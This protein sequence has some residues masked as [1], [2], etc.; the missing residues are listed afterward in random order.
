MQ[1]VSIAGFY[2]LIFA[3][4]IYASR[5]SRGASSTDA[6]LLA[7]RG[8]PLWV[9]VMTMTAT[10]VGGGYIN[11]AA[12]AI[13]DPTLGIVWAQAPW[14]YALSMVLGGLFF[15]RRMRQQKYKTLLDP[16]ERRYGATTASWLFLPA[17]IG[18]VF[19]SAAILVALGTTF[20][21]VLDLDVRT[22]ILISAAVAVGYTLVGGLWSVAYTDVVQLVCMLGGL[23]VAIPFAVNRVG[24]IE[25]VWENAA[26]KMPPFPT[27]AGIWTWIDMALLLCLGGIP[28]QVY[29]QRVLAARD[30]R[31]AVRLSLFASLG[32]LLMAVP[33]LVIGAVGL[34]ADWS[35]TAA[36][37]APPPA[38]VLP[39][40]LVQLTP[41]MIGVV[42]LGA[43]AAAVMSSV[44]SS[45]LSASS[46]FVWNVYRPQLRPGAD[47]Q[48]LRYA[49]RATILVVG[50]AATSL[51]LVVQSVYA[52]W[53]LCADLVYIIL[54][55]QLV[56][57]L[58][59]KWATRVG[60]LSGAVVGL[61]LRLGGGEPLLGIPAWLPYPWTTP[62]GGTH[63]PF[64]TFSM[65][66]GLATIWF[67]SRV[68]TVRDD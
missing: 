40:V 32:C 25:T 56:I 65:L 46:M 11:G 41:G 29:F 7:D 22:S 10:W 24:G 50:G 3:V 30:E 55:P 37:V 67:V 38:T 14:G 61:V 52:L 16:F 44:D 4:G 68:T 2:G 60:V 64:R 17:L 18:E 33:A 19:W 35:T 6:L 28:W 54:F 36:G 8:M 51:A 48:E 27:G 45:I 58:Y 63:F 23:C 26:T 31:T 47:D 59:S 20:G 9:G 12:E 15:A 53:Y 21:V 13:F 39:H 34:T 66:A 1:L 43:I 5:R 62:D 49:L 57:V 42:G